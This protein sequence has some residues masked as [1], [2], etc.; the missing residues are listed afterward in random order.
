MR[1][2]I[3]GLAGLGLVAGAGSVAYHNHGAT[4]RIKGPNGQTQTVN[5]AFGKQRFDCPAGTHDRTEPLLIRS[6]RIKLTLRGI[7]ADLRRID[8]KYPKGSHRP[9]RSVVLRF[10]AE[11]RRG[12]R[13]ERAGAATVRQYNAILD[14]D[15]TPTSG[16]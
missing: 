14:R 7:E 16:G 2:I 11:L 8:R 15:C 4:V 1:R 12:Q 3:A 10:N 13:L 5:I 6:A 9:P